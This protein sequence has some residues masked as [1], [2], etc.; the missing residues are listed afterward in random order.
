LLFLVVTTAAVAAERQTLSG[1]VPA[2]V[3]RLNLQ[4]VGRLPAEQR[5]NLAIGLPLR[6]PDALSNLLQQLYDPGSTNYHRYLTPVQFTQR[7]G[8]TA[9]DYQAVVDFARSNGWSVTA[10]DPGRILVH[11]NASVAD[12][13]KLCHVTLRLYQHPTEARQF[14]APDTEPSLDLIIPVSNIAGMDNYVRPH[15]AG[16][17]APR[18]SSASPD[19]GS[20]PGGT[21]IG[22]DFRAA[23]A[24]GVW[25]DGSGQTVGLLEF[26]GYYAND[27]QMYEAEAGLPNVPLTNVLVDSFDGTPSTIVEAPMDIEVVI[28]MAPGLSRVIVYEADPNSSLGN[29]ILEQMAND[30]IAAQISSSWSFQTNS[31]SSAYLMQMAAQGQSFF[32]ASGDYGANNDGTTSQRQFADNPYVTSVGGTT[33]TTS[34]SDGSW[35]SE[36]TWNDIIIGKGSNGSGGGI[37]TT[38]PIPAWQAGTSMSANQG[39]VTQRNYPDVAMAAHNIW[40]IYNNGTTEAAGGTSAAAPLW[41]GFTALVNQQAAY[42]GNAAVGFLNPA[43]YRLGNSPQYTA[44]FHD[45]TT[46]NNTNLESPN[47]FCAVPGYDLCTGWGTPTGI[48]LIDALALSDPLLV[49]PASGFS[50]GGAAGGPFYPD[51][52]TFYL[53]NTGSAALSWA[54]ADPSSFLTVSPSS[55]ILAEGGNTN[56]TVTV[57]P[58]TGSLAVGFYSDNLVFLNLTLNTEQVRPLTLQVGLPPLTFDDLHDS[59]YEIPPGYGGLNWSNFNFFNASTALDPSGYKAGMV[60]APNV[61]YNVDAG[62]ASIIS[63]APFD[64]ISAFLT[65]AWD[66]NLNVEA[67]G[68]IGSTL[69]YDV[70]NTLSATMPSNIQ[71]NYFGVTSVSFLSSGGTPY[72]G[73]SETGKQ[74]VMDNV[75]AV[76]HFTPPI[77]PALQNVKSA[78]GAISFDW[79]ATMGQTYQVQYNTNL[80]SSNWNNLDSPL[81]ATNSMLTVSN[82]LTNG[83]RYYR[84]LL[85]P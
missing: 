70:T 26:G 62:A 68:Y 85:L 23:Y 37:S 58:S 5:L 81:S 16:L 72:S 25:L 55:G 51:T 79:S 10:T 18:G 13:E 60:S 45:I 43:I 69:A 59:T 67:R 14:F 24:P 1:H 36:T 4:P 54:V 21:L 48:N 76:T 84:L 42:Y 38:F 50:T 11:V 40:A 65:A 47:L 77:A 6:N 35:I 73:Y 9:S 49:S 64:L 15:P 17:D 27:I 30:G 7:F 83:Q 82:R 32:H 22:Y 12:I 41:A 20:A 28:S 74:F 61:I 2:A 80:C 78:A 53:T 66:D 46:G 56:V 63:P 31:T 57:A 44:V 71:F 75:V 8:P 52:Q 34:G 33:L 29:D 3:T 39:S 19:A